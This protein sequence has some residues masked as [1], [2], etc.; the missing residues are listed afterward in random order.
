MIRFNRLP[1]LSRLCFSLGLLVGV[2][3]TFPSSWVEGVDDD[4]LEAIVSRVAST[5]EDRSRVERAL[6]WARDQGRIADLID[7]IGEHGLHHRALP[8]VQIAIDLAT[9]QGHV[10]R[11]V[12][13]LEAA[14]E[15][16][17][18]PDL[19]HQLAS[20]WLS[21]GWPQQARQVALDHLESDLF[22][23]IR[24]GLQLF[25]D[26]TDS[27]PATQISTTTLKLL[28][29]RS[30]R[31]KWAVALLQQRG[32]LDDAL[33]IALSGGLDA[34]VRQLLASGARP[35]AGAM[36]LR[37][38]RL[39]GETH[40]AGSSW[41]DEG[42]EEGA[43]WRASMGIESILLSNP[44]RPLRLPPL[45]VALDRLEA[46]DERGARRA[47]A[48]WRLGGG[49][50]T[51]QDVSTRLILDQ[52]KPSWL[53][54]DRLPE[55][56][57]RQ[58]RGSFAAED[59]HL[60]LSAALRSFEGTPIEARLWFQ[61]GR[62]SQ[63]LDWIHRSRRIHPAGEV[64]LEWSAG[65][66]ARWTLPIEFTDLSEVCDPADFLPQATWPPRG[67]LIGSVAG[68]PVRRVGL[69]ASD[70]RY[71]LDHWQRDPPHKDA[72]KRSQPTDRSVRLRITDGVWL[73]GDAQ[74]LQVIDTT[75]RPERVLV[76][77]TPRGSFSLLSSDGL[78]TDAV[79]DKIFRISTPKKWLRIAPV[80]PQM[81]P[82]M[83]SFG[84][85]A[86]RRAR[87]LEPMRWIDFRPTEDGAWWVDVA[88]VSG[89]FN[90]EAPTM[91][92]RQLPEEM[93]PVRSETIALGPLPTRHLRRIGTRRHGIVPTS[94][95]PQIDAID[96]P[97]PLLPNGERSLLTAGHRQRVVVTDS[98]L[99]GLFEN[100]ASRASWW[101]ELL[102]PPLR[103]VGGFAALPAPT[104][105]PD[106][107][108]A[109]GATPRL[110]EVPD[111]NGASRFLLLAS[112]PIIIDVDPA[113]RISPSFSSCEAFAGGTIDDDG[114]LWLLDATGDQLM[115]RAGNTILPR[116]GAY[117][118]IST[119]HGI[120]ILGIDGGQTWLMHYDGHSA[121]E[122]PT[123]PLPDERDRPHL[124]VAALA[125]WG[126]EVLLLADRLWL[127]SRDGKSHRALTPA[128][129]DGVYRPV[130]WVQSCPKIWPG[131][132]ASTRIELD[133]PW[134]VTEIWSTP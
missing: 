24:L 113:P 134:G 85:N 66:E 27:P 59:A 3:G 107:P 20:M 133:R 132:N 114:Q 53:G 41:I 81:E 95:Q 98:G 117:Q 71:W 30:G 19:R 55:S 118:L 116:P 70:Q 17:A 99:V 110:I 89:L 10:E 40:W 34:E 12:Q 33:E 15:L 96:A 127:I 49:G 103:G 126:D 67:A 124:R 75:M 4:P 87:D 62:L 39:L 73:A 25:E 128:P 31:W 56:L 72:M 111:E 43:R 52:R 131:A 29:D 60:A 61:A 65:I 26:R 8:T 130:H 5:P 23:D 80:A 47:V 129:Q 82:S 92:A 76:E 11:A 58:L 102:S 45:R 7:A 90:S 101:K 115:S 79:L 6:L 14:L 64:A 109:D 37:L 68:E 9:E 88:G 16:D 78:P 108:W 46:N 77:L 35:A 1:P 119:R 21:G 94:T 104:V 22:A 38:A 105:R 97:Q 112:Q 51:R 106:L 84:E 54:P 125:R 100:G 28:A 122:I 91:T 121:Q 123:P 36:S 48:L 32:E 74:S 13:I 83:R 44:A 18:S 2:L 63:N 120:I 57:E 86:C 50:I 42:T 69:P 93:T